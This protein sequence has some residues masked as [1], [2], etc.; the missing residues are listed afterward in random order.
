MT[1]TVGGLGDGLLAE[2]RAWWVTANPDSHRD[3]A[4]TSPRPSGG[5]FDTD[6]PYG[7]PGHSGAPN[8]DW[9]GYRPG[10]YRRTHV[11]ADSFS[12]AAV[13]KGLREGRVGVDHGGPISGFDARLRAGGNGRGAGKAVG[14]RGTTFGGTPHVKRGG[15]AE[16]VMGIAPA[17]DPN[18]SRF[19]PPPGW[20]SFGA[21]SS[22]PSPTGRSSP[23]PGSGW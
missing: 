6:G 8:L 16:P 23:P 19:E 4:D 13:M 7:G 1:A 18:R 17:I 5:K 22:D 15:R 10:R 11:G 12:C 2:G 21:R 14:A 3:Y 9:G 20:T